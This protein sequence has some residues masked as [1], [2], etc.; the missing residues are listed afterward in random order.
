MVR[1]PI[2]FKNLHPLVFFFQNSF[3]I[4]RI[5]R[6]SKRSQPDPNLLKYYRSFDPEKDQDFYHR[7]TSSVNQLYGF[8]GAR[9]SPIMGIIGATLF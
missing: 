4:K 5:A 2:H 8:V 1:Y 3:Q 9:D 6:F 7:P